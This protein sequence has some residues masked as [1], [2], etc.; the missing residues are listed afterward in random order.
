MI[1]KNITVQPFLRWAGSKRQL[2][3]KLKMFW[4]EGRTR[5]VE[6]FMGSAC[7]FFNLQPSKALLADINSDLVR[8]FSSIRDHPS[9]V[10]RRLAEFP[11]SKATYY[12]L[13]ANPTDKLSVTDTAARFIYLNRFCF[14][15]LFRTNLRGQFNVPF[16]PTGSG[17]LPSEQ[18]LKQCAVLLERAELKCAD[19]EDTLDHV[20]EGDFVYLDPPYAVKNRRVFREYSSSPFTHH[21]LDRLAKALNKIDSLGAH[22]VV[23]YADCREGREALGNWRMMRARTKRNIAGFAQHRRYAYELI[24]TNIDRF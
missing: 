17:A 2:L 13:R 18:H 3:P 16:A 11:V 5:Y 24:V 12:E 8:T 23:S 9:R 20:R 19:F 14:N 10:A 4:F 21:D 6:P 1:E 22:F 15:G 7:F